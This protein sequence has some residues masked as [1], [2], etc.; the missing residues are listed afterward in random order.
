M[1]ITVN[2]NKGLYYVSFDGKLIETTIH[3]ELHLVFFKRF[4]WNLYDVVAKQV[5]KFV[6]KGVEYELDNELSVLLKEHLEVFFMSDNN[7]LLPL[8][9]L[10]NFN[11]FYCASIP[12]YLKYVHEGYEHFK[13]FLKEYPVQI[14]AICAFASAVNLKKE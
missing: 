14:A 8:N 6:F 2:R 11:S 3:S 4:G 12:G 10:K 5:K 13:I 9:Y 7:I 1:N